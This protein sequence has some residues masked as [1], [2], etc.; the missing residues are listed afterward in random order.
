MVP[1]KNFFVDVLRGDCDVIV[2]SYPA[3]SEVAIY[4][5][6]SRFKSPHH[7]VILHQNYFSL[8]FRQ[9]FMFFDNSKNKGSFWWR[10]QPVIGQFQ[11]KIP[12]NEQFL[13]IFQLTQLFNHQLYVM[14]HLMGYFT[15]I[16]YNLRLR[17]IYDV[18]GAPYEKLKILISPN[19]IM[20]PLD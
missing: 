13:L 2:T 19:T 20:W 11:A 7:C 1:F 5:I 6:I 10:H 17:V 15:K 16:L 4:C 14:M 18:I 8:I 12:K 3:Y 9:Y